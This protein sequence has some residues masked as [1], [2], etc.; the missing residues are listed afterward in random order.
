MKETLDEEAAALVGAERKALATREQEVTS[1]HQ[2]DTWRPIHHRPLP[3]P[4]RTPSRPFGEQN[5][6]VQR[7]LLR[8][9]FSPAL[10]HQ[11]YCTGLTIVMHGVIRRKRSPVSVA[12][13]DSSRRKGRGSFKARVRGGR[14]ANTEGT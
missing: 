6:L 5:N 9:D 8:R 7:P 4:L 13:K 10:K 14:G 3:L 12:A 1:V 2:V 11:M